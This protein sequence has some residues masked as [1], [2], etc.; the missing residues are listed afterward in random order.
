MSKITSKTSNMGWRFDNSYSKL[1]DT[2]LSK[3]API[4]VKA[5]KVVILNHSL[6][7]KFRKNGAIVEHLEVSNIK[8]FFNHGEKSP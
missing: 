5:P 6:S 7:K 2:M 4:P 3:L 1:P 8:I